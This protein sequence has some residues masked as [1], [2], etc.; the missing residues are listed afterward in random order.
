MMKQKSTFISKKDLVFQAV[1]TN[2][3]ETTLFLGKMHPKASQGITRESRALYQ[4]LNHSPSSGN[5]AYLQR[6]I[7]D[8]TPVLQCQAV[9]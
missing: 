8:Y 5:V 7:A 2:T 3:R 1:V 4:P 9:L 6:V